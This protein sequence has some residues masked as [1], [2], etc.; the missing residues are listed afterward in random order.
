MSL[1]RGGALNAVSVAAKQPVRTSSDTIAPALTILR[2]AP[3]LASPFRF[4]RLAE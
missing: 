4:A 3:T 2:S 1:E